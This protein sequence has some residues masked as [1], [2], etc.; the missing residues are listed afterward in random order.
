[1]DARSQQELEPLRFGRLS[2]SRDSATHDDKQAREHA[3]GLEL[4]ADAGREMA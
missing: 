2:V 1:M 3:A 4:R